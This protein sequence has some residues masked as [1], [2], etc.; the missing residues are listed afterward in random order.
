MSK[1]QSSS[2][3]TALLNRCADPATPP[4]VTVTNDLLMDGALRSALRRKG[5]FVATLDR[6]PVF[7]KDTLLHA[8]Y[9]SGEF[10][11]YFGFNWDAL[12][13]TLCDFSWLPVNGGV[14]LIW[15]NPALLQQRAP[16]VYDTFVEVLEE[17]A[18]LRTDAAAP[19]LRVLVPAH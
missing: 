16:E 4:L 15:R 1:P 17:A 12:K 10:P 14:A 19:P 5:W 8:L 11:A 6:A 3:I 2:D 7:G 13:D 9:Q 18:A